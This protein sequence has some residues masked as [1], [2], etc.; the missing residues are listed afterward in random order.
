[1]ATGTPAKAAGAT[2]NPCTQVAARSVYKVRTLRRS[3]LTASGTPARQ[4]ASSITHPCDT[5]LPVTCPP[6][7]T[8]CTSY[9][10]YAASPSP[11]LVTAFKA[12]APL[13]IPASRGCKAGREEGRVSM[14]VGGLGQGYPQVSRLR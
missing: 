7:R 12:D 5:Q 6:C 9:G 3:Q 10:M 4:P 8:F 11:G 1:M 14:G 13:E 2:G